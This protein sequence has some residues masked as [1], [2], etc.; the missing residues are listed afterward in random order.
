MK[1]ITAILLCILLC[2]SIAG[3]SSNSGSVDSSLSLV[4]EF[5]QGVQTETTDSSVPD[6]SET[7]D[8]KVTTTTGEATETTVPDNTVETQTGTP[9]TPDIRPSGGSTGSGSNK[10]ESSKEPDAS[11]ET[12]PP[13]TTTPPETD[14][15]TESTPKEESKPAE[16]TKPTETEKPKDTNPPT[17]ET[18]P[19][20]TTPPTETTKPEETEPQE[21]TDPYAYPFNIE[22]IRQDCIALGRSYGFTLD[23]SLT[24]NNSSWAGAE[25]AS[26]N[27]QGTRLKRLL[28][29]MVEYYSPAYR[30]DM[31]LPAVN[32]TAFN[33]YCESIGNGT[34]RIYFLFLL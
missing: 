16:T 22:Q 24:P 20:E 10:A 6:K 29:E 15:T 11:T 26:S 2:V 27:T 12:K 4:S 5:E 28:T 19:E 3:C 14:A 21:P 31:G 33:I 34:Y 23:E 17:E 25:T 13:Q 30:E 18:K 9:N 8:G 32:I 7:D 1:R